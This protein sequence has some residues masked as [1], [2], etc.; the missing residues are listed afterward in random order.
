[1]QYAERKVKCKHPPEVIAGCSQFAG[2]VSG[3]TNGITD[4]FPGKLFTIQLVT[5][6]T[7]SIR[8]CAGK[9]NI[10]TGYIH[11]IAVE[12]SDFSCLSTA[13][14]MDTFPLN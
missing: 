14:K 7:V 11:R 4:E 9:I 3:K 13:L 2:L 10:Y 6:N 8:V 1:M 12:R 5:E